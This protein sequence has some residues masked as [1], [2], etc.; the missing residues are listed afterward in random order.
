MDLMLP[1]GG[2]RVCLVLQRP[3]FPLGKL[4][5]ILAVKIKKRRQ[6]VLAPVEPHGEIE[7]CQ[8]HRA[9]DKHG[10]KFTTIV[11]SGKQ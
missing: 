11:F 6:K 5:S 8:L 9:E 3:L 1:R 4:S 2:G 7:A 10:T